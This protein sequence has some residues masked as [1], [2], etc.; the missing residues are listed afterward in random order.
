MD[1]A[2]KDMIKDLK[3][4]S[5]LEFICQDLKVCGRREF[6]ELLKLRY[7]YVVSI[8]RKKQA[9]KD[10][11]K[12]EEEANKPEMTQEELEAMVDKELDETIKRVEKEK[13]K[14]L[15]KERIKDQK[16][17]IRK[18]MSVI[19]ASS[20]NNDED[21]IL[22]AKTWDKLKSIEDAEDIQ[23]YLPKRLDD[24]DDEE[25]MDPTE[26]KYRFLNDGA[27]EK[28]DQDI[29]VSSDDISEDEAVTRVDRMA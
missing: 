5:D 21:L 13:K 8:E 18:K 16:Q 29:E 28:P 23:K 10:A 2:A 17:D 3:A 6:Q 24:S 19:A 4:P 12:A 26:R 11:K 25:N 15:K 9:I 27:M 20:M 22:D 7:K 1:D 14:A